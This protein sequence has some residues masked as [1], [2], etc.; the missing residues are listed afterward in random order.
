MSVYGGVMSACLCYALGTLEQTE[1]HP[2]SLQSVWAWREGLADEH[3]QNPP[4]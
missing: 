1:L 4:C 2:L 3:S